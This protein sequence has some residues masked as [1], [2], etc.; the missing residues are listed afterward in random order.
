MPRYVNPRSFA[1]ALLLLCSLCLL[2]N[3]PAWAEEETAGRE[4]YRGVFC[5]EILRVDKDL[6]AVFVQGEEKRLGRRHFFTYAETQYWDERKRSAFDKLM[7]GS[8]VGVRYFAEGDVRVADDIFI[9]QG[10]C[11]PQRYWRRPRILTAEQRAQAEAQ[12]KALEKQAASEKAEEK[13]QPEEGHGSGEEQKEA[14]AAH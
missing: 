11:E 8:T 12:K 1:S 4:H 13:E 3:A 7:E 5:G 14:P 9:V 10:K 6:K 2:G